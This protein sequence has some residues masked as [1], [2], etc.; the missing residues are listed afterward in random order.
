MN[1]YLWSLLYEHDEKLW[2]MH[3]YGTYESALQHS[4]NLNTAEPEKVALIVTDYREKMN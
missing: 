3:I 4:I 2:S 1:D